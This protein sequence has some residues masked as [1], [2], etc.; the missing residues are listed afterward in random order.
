MRFI[1]MINNLLKQKLTLKRKNG[2]VFPNI[3]ASVQE[4]I[5]INDISVPIEEGDSLVH[6]LPSGLTQNY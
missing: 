4:K 3:L 1:I 6:V 5:Y 2:K